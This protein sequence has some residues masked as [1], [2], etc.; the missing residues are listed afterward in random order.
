MRNRLHIYQIKKTLA[1]IWL[2]FLQDLQK[3]VHKLLSIII[4][5]F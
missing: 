5:L 2:F 4:L 1:K 3:T